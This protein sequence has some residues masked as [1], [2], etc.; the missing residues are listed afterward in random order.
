MRHAAPI[1]AQ[2]R[3]V[4]VPWKQRDTNKDP[5]AGIGIPHASREA[6]V[7]QRFEVAGSSS[8]IVQEH[9]PLLG[10]AC[11][12]AGYASV[13]LKG[14]GKPSWCTHA[15]TVEQISSATFACRLVPI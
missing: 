14:L 11:L 12:A 4:Q 3:A 7:Q 2:G 15:H 8:T 6:A 9:G 1:L 10:L 13:L 5:H